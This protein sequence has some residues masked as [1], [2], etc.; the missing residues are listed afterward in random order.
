MAGSQTTSHYLI[1][2]PLMAAATCLPWAAHAGRDA[3]VSPQSAA[4]RVAYIQKVDPGFEVRIMDVTT[5]QIHDLL[6]LI[7]PPGPLSVARHGQVLLVFGDSALH[8]LDLQ[9]QKQEEISPLPEPVLAKG[10]LNA[11]PENA[12][13]L[14]DG[15]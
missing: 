15:S 12:G 13:Y 4:P 2:L 5:G 1:A 7:N 10:F 14:Q 6:H 11:T 9:S 3:V 8:V